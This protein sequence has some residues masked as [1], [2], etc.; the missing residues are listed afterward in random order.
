MQSLLAAKGD[1]LRPA[2]LAPVAVNTA[3]LAPV[4]ARGVG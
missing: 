4:A 1:G 2:A 3:A